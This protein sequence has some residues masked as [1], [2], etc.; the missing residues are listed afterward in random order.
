[1]AGNDYRSGRRQVSF[2][3]DES[4][5]AA[6]KGCAAVRGWSVTK[7]I[8]ELLEREVGHGDVG[9]GSG[10]HEGAGASGGANGA[11]SVR[12]GGGDSESGASGRGVDWDAMLAVGRAAKIYSGVDISTLDPIEE[13]A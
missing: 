12:G 3:V 5:W 4:L 6:V 7:L 9:V 11:H 10:D 2:V 1:M 13:I 8:T